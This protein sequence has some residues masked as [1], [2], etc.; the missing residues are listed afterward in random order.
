MRPTPIPNRLA[1]L[2]ES[3]DSERYDRYGRDGRYGRIGP[4]SWSFAQTLIGAAI[5]LVPW[6]T[7][8]LLSQSATPAAAGSAQPV[9]HAQDLLIGMGALLLTST[10]EA[11]FLIAPL[12]YALRTRPLGTPLR[13]GLRMLGFR[14]T[15]LSNPPK[16]VRQGADSYP[17]RRDVLLCGS[18]QSW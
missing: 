6:V 8:V 1:H 17:L 14:R 2:L 10:V 9:S 5:T 11:A 15:S 18:V 4:V 12:Y 13:E 3:E 7:L 16:T